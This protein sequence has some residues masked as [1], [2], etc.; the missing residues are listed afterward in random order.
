VCVCAKPVQMHHIQQRRRLM[1]VCMHVCM[2][3]CIC[4]CVCM[5]TCADA[6]HPTTSQTDV[7]MYACMYVRMYMCVCVYAKHVQMH[8]I[9]L[10]RRLVYVCMYV[11][12]CVCVYVCMLVSMCEGSWIYVTR[13]TD[14]LK[15]SRSDR[16]ID[17]QTDRCK[18]M[19]VCPYPYLYV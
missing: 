3:V 15:V 8:R 11:C 10:R 13:Q 5:Q 4:V 12:I 9:Q 6:S 18:L 1:Y 7:C 14:R 16:H 2:Y 19:Y 17:R